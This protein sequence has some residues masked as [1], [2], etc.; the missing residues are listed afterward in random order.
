MEIDRKTTILLCLIF[1][2][3]AFFYLYRLDSRVLWEDES[4]T[5][6]LAVNILKYGIPMGD[7]GKNR[8]VFNSPGDINKENVWV[9]SPW[10][11][12]YI[13]AVSFAIFGKNEFAA[14][15]PFA[16]LGFLSVVFLFYV[17]W[18]IF[19]DRRMALI[20]LLLLVTSEILILHSRQCKYY[21]IA[22]FMQVLFIYGFYMVLKRKRPGIV[23]I[24][25]ALTCQFYSNYMFVPG[26]LLLLLFAGL[27]FR[28]KYPGVFYDVI[29]AAMIV[30]VF[31]LIWVI[32]AHL[33]VQFVNTGT[34]YYH[35]YSKFLFY[36]MEINMAMFP[37]LLLLLL[38]YFRKSDFVVVNDVSKDMIFFILVMIPFQIVFI[39]NF[40]IIFTRYI[41]VLVPAFIVLQSLILRKTPPLLRYMVLG[42]LCF[43][44]L[45]GYVGLYSFKPV[46]TITPTIEVQLLRIT[47]MNIFVERIS[48]YVN[49]TEEVI[50][51]LNENTQPGQS[52]LVSGYET[53]FP[54][55][56]YTQLKVLNPQ[57]VKSQNIEM[58]D[59]IFPQTVS[60]SY[61]QSV[62]S[63]Y[64]A[65][66]SN[67]MKQNYDIVI[68]E[69]HKSS[70]IGSIPEPYLY[71]YFT[72]RRKIPFIAFKKKTL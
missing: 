3:G 42:I 59:W 6:N 33:W 34:G 64:L 36:L 60:G 48:P 38:V 31:A 47:L 65:P 17:V 56:F 58:P 55:I 69:V 72:P 40:P 70:G 57:Y 21:A 14:R 5:A 8:L 53:E 63:P 15:L 62:L 46:R 37:L 20:A 18:D 68:I 1:I 43:T 10:L 4:I 50:A 27:V 44:N 61:S 29:M 26:N 32:Y 23:F 2:V 16:V 28:K 12:E 49:R 24:V 35:Y 19:K 11:S 41:I 45:I 39:I 7:D 13:T 30:S 25:I 67:F 52:L 66:Y 22:V 54:V 51:F 71:E 9:Y